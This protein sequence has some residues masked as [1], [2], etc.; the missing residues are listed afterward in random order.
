MPWRSRTFLIPNGHKNPISGSQVKAILLKGW[1]GGASVGEGLRLQPAQQAC[2]YLITFFRGYS[3]NT[4]VS[5]SFIKQWFV[6]IYLR[7]L[8]ALMPY[9][10]TESH[11]LQ[12]LRRFWILKGI[13]IA[14][15]VQKLW[16]FCWMGGFCLLVELQLG[17]ACADLPIPKSPTKIWRGSKIASKI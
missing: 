5:N 13:Q 12:F 17:R 2:L 16:R 14:L 7:R 6:K 1:I 11:I 9:F 15:L 8:H 3:T 4:S 10:M